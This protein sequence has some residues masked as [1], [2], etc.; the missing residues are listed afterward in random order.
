[1]LIHLLDLHFSLYAVFSLE[2]QLI[3]VLEGK[4][5]HGS[6]NDAGKKKWK[7]NKITH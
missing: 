2:R 3:D 6:V 5:L 1:M 4:N 7:Y